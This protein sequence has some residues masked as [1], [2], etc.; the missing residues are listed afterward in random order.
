MKILIVDDNKNIREFIKEIIADLG[1]QIAEASNGLMAITKVKLFNPEIILMD[2][3][4]DI[5]DGIEAT[6]EIRKLSSTARI[7]IV[8]D[9]S[10]KS[11]IDKAM[12]AGADEYLLKKEL[13]KLK[14]LLSI[15]K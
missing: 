13:I 8:T 4:M 10:E 9:Y 6:I 12:K 11:L 3:K 7:I 2:I 5:M 15:N 1:F 14:N